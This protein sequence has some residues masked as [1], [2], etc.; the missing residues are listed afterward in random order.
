MQP[1]A[2]HAN[3]PQP[4]S[5]RVRS[6]RERCG[7]TQAELADILQVSRWTIVQWEAGARTPRH[8]DILLAHAERTAAKHVALKRR[9]RRQVQLA[10]ARKRLA[11]LEREEGPRHW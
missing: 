2:T 4:A 11:E 9:K 10:H 8:L 3:P 6:L 5:L 7:L 1:D